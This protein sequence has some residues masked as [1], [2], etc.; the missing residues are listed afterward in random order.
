MAYIAY[1]ACIAYMAS[2]DIP[3]L[4]GF[5]IPAGIFCHARV[6]RVNAAASGQQERKQAWAWDGWLGSE[7]QKFPVAVV[8]DRAA[9]WTELQGV[10]DVI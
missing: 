3:K 1:M 7:V 8:V 4:R 9:R 10:T 2:L 6:G 5:R